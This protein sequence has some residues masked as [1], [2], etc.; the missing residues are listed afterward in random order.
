MQAL[1]APPSEGQT[2][3][4]IAVAPAPLITGAGPILWSGAAAV[5]VIMA[6]VFSLLLRG[7]TRRK[8]SLRSTER[9]FFKPAGDGA[10]ITFDDA[11]GGRA[12]I[13]LREPV[14]IEDAPALKKKS[15]GAFS[16]LFAR[17][18]RKPI[19]QGATTEIDLG[20]PQSSPDSAYRDEGLASV[21]IGRDVVSASRESADEINARLAA[22]IASERAGQLREAARERVREDEARQRAQAAEG[23]RRLQE[24]EAIERAARLNDEA[25]R[26]RFE[27][28]QWQARR[29]DDMP[30]QPLSGEPPFAGAEMAA[31]GFGAGFGGASIGSD[32]RE[33]AQPDDMARTLS[34]VEEALNAQ[35][36][37]I[38]S[39][40]RAL[41]DSFA[42]R[43][44]ARLD[45]APVGLAPPA[46]FS[47]IAR[48]IASLRERLDRAAS[49][50][51]EAL[52]QELTL[53]REAIAGR[54]NASAPVVQLA[55]II[56][57]TLPPETYDMPATLANHRRVDCLVKLP[58]P[59]GPIA[60]DA[61]FPVEAFSVLGASGARR[62]S[63][64][65]NEFRRIAI[66]HIVD[67]A[68]RLIAP[69]ETAA[70]AIMFLPSE[71]MYTE[72]HQRFP[73]I[74]QDAWRARVWI[75]SPTTLMATLHTVQAAL[76]LAEPR[77]GAQFLRD[78]TAR[79]ITEVTDLRRRIASLEEA[80]SRVQP[81]LDP[82]FGPASGQASAPTPPMRAEAPTP[83]RNAFHLSV[84]GRAASPTPL[85]PAPDE[86]LGDLVN[87]TRETA[88]QP[89]M[90]PLFPLR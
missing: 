15:G 64:A 53:I 43:L 65:E 38:Q 30:R 56:R 36:E 11:S 26:R 52:R 50:D 60:I 31:G 39:E 63:D 71:T 80:L 41:L 90:R 18:E 12:G 70:S 9:E 83:S 62:N 66:R 5:I 54:S 87:E 32:R 59:S 47:E 2:T 20:E 85:R 42:Q 49:V 44:F 25:E 82:V 58:R 69:G 68:E 55:D 40:T 37:A 22:E 6:L 33:R 67:I 28:D 34:D 89:T 35:R 29:I 4:A 74:V 79:V 8:A 17:R 72:L 21:S 46:A 3:G 88:G 75:V 23:A 57:D 84:A 77:G 16:G 86:R 27:T 51:P 13:D 14:F 1:P 76:A 19:D 78:D 24:R 61:R 48:E 10:E 73:D 81:A 7:R 45:A